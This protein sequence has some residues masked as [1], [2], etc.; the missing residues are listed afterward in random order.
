MMSAT[1]FLIAALAVAR[2]TRLITDDYLTAGPRS[3]AVRRLGTSS[4]AA[5]LITC[6]WCTGMWISAAA[7]GIW[8]WHGESPWVQVPAAALALSQAVGMASTIG[9]DD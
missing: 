9:R 7:A 4:K 8:W 1:A 2:V 5:Y 3:W 6:Q